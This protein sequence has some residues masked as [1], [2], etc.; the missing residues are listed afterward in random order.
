[1]LRG[2]TSRPQA[3]NSIG[4]RALHNASSPTAPPFNLVLSLNCKAVEGWRRHA[5]LSEDPEI[6][7]AMI[8]HLSYT[9]GSMLEVVTYRKGNMSHA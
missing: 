7:K 6:S 8:G 3:F 1:M 9:L 4:R 5:G 2:Q